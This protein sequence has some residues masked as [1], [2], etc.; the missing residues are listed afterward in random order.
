M[1]FKIPLNQIFYGP[2]GTG[3]T[4]SI[5]EK[6]LEILGFDLDG[7][8]RKEIKDLYNKMTA[9]GRIVFTTFHQS[10]SYEDFIEGI[11]PITKDRE[12]VYHVESGVFKRLC[13]R[14]MGAGVTAKT[15]LSSKNIDSDFERIFSLFISKLKE[16]QKDIRKEEP[17][18]FKSRKTKVKFEKIEGSSIIISHLNNGITESITKD[19]ISVIYSKFNNPDEISSI[20]KQLQGED[21]VSAEWTTSDF[22]VFLTLKEFEATKKIYYKYNTKNEKDNFVFIIDEINRGNV[23]QIFGELITLLEDDKRIGKEEAIEVVLPYSKQKFGI[24]SNLYILGTMNTA[25]R[26]VE[27]LDTA[28]RRRFS[29]S[30]IYPEPEIIASKGKLRDYYGFLDNIN[31]VE[32]LEIINF[33]IEILLDRDH[34]IGHSYFLTIENWFDLREVFH[35]KIIPLL[36]EYFYGDYGK[37]GLV[38]GKDFIENSF[39]KRKYSIA[40]FEDYGID[41]DERRKYYPINFLKKDISYFKIAINNLIKNEED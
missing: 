23:S 25:D 7:K 10:M 29:F 41:Y 40:S 5:I 28:L 36:K 26:S 38:L 19:R 24:P 35:N 27:A 18:I 2:P 14:I 20:I 30:E 4:Y 37:I 32:L 39:I 11:K 21:E 17:L 12:I 34:Q 6:S 15:Y 9:D 13:D 22:T 8:S 33:R 1:D 31:L 16:I 3:K